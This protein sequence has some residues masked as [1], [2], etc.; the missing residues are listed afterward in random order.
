MPLSEF[1][2]IDA[3]GQVFSAVVNGQKITI[4]LRYNT[5]S[6]HFSMDLGI[7]DVPAL[8]GR[9][10]ASET[11][12]LEPFDLGIGSIFAAD[13]NGLGRDATLANFLSGAVR[14]YHFVP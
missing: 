7:D 10:V 12:I 11:D 8:T 13:V 2:I 1:D 6:Q 9:K 3:P 4:R 14:L 5:E